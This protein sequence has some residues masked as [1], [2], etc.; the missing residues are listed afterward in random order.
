MR[1]AALALV[2]TLALAG[3]APAQEPASAPAPEAAS[4]E[5]ELRERVRALEERLRRL[6]V[7][8]PSATSAPGADGPG[9]AG[10]SD[11]G[12]PGDDEPGGAFSLVRTF[13]EGVELYASVVG[14]YAYHL[15]DPPGHADVIPLRQDLFDHDTFAPTWARIGIARPVGRRQELDAGFRLELV[16]GRAV[17][18]VLSQDP[19]FLGGEPINLG[20]AYATLQVPGLYEPMLVHL[21]RVESWF[22]VEALDPAQAPLLTTSFLGLVTPN[23]LTGLF[24]ETELPAG[25]EVLLH[26]G[27]GA[28]L[29]IDDNDAK[30]VGGRVRW[31]GPGDLSLSLG[32]L[33]GPEG[34]GNVSDQRWLLD[35]GLEWAVTSSTRLYAEALYGQEEGAALGGGVAKLGGALLIVRQV[36]WRAERGA[37]ELALTLR[38]AVLRDLG[39]SETGLRQT[40]SEGTLQLELIPVEH[41]WLRVEYRLDGSNREFF[42]GHRGLPSRR[43]QQTVA[44]GIAVAF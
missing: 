12:A 19:E 5:A 23:T 29:V 42:P 2:A 16:A 6:E 35:L 41:A 34:A 24:V 32:A 39:G 7:A 17:E 33:L 25:F 10:A 9:E 8:P 4:A 30:S 43:T 15:A 38:G 3:P 37:P 1:R 36:L 22:G 21:G 14:T 18:R 26:V 44:V 11:P 20:E 28:D 13:F 40:L 31:L 27:N